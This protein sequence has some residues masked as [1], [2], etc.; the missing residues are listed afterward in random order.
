[1]VCRWATV[2]GRDTRV[3]GIVACYTGPESIP[4]EWLDYREAL[5]DWPFVD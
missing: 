1:M 2:L 3:G 4:G 5:P